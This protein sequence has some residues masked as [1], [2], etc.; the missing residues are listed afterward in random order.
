MNRSILRSISTGRSSNESLSQMSKDRDA[1]PFEPAWWCPGPHLQT[2]WRAFF[3]KEPVP[4][5]KRVR[6]ETLDG[7]FIDLD[8]LKIGPINNKTPVILLLH[9]LE[10]SSHSQYILGLLNQCRQ[11]RWLGI[12]MNFRSCSGEM[13]RL[14]KSYHSGE[15]GDL[16][17]VVERIIDFYPDHPLF[18]AGYSLGGNILLKWLGERQNRLPQEVLAAAAVSV[19]FDLKKSVL[20]IDEPGFNRSV[21]AAS[22][23]KTL[24]EKTLFKIRKFHL[25]FSVTSIQNIKT[26]YEFDEV[27]TAPIHGFRDAEDYWYQSSSIRYLD[28]IQIPVYL[29]NSKDDPLLSIQSFPF[30]QIKMNP[31][32][33]NELTEKGGHLGFVSGN[34]PWKARYLTD[35][36]IT[37]FFQQ[38]LEGI[39]G[40]VPEAEFKNGRIN[41]MNRCVNQN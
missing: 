26:F 4:P 22:V 17:W 27:V 35:L 11:K 12:A 23:L 6:W 21:Y 13:N 28:K 32:I 10:G 37:G 20:Q 40:P 9:G 19:P 36:R 25:N 30:R 34:L 16:N 3:G 39:K 38:T 15:T 1:A 18:I 8:F 14:L 2:A 5:L 41:S 29:L 24:K 31:F 7:D 33:N